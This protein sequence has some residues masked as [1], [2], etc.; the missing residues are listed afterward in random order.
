MSNSTTD[1][2]ES[3]RAL[4]DETS[5]PPVHAWNPALTRDIDMRIARNG[6]WFYQGSKIERKRM[7]KLFS[8]VLRL[9]EDGHTYLVT[10]QERL[11]ICVEDAPFTAVLLHKE[12][13]GKRQALVFTLNTGEKVLAGEHHPIVVEYPKPDG[14][15]SPYVLVRDKLRALISRSVFIELAQLAQYGVAMPRLTEQA[16]AEELGVFSDGCFMPLAI[17]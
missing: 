14:E 4:L 9:D 16:G 8:T 6:D 5:L 3:L 12:G 2:L 7:V 15:P 11:R 1:S 13:E 17:E 10:P